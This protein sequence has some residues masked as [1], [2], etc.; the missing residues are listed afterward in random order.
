M[1]QQQQHCPFSLFFFVFINIQTS[2][3][4][5]KKVVNFSFSQAKVRWEFKVTQYRHISILSLKGL[6]S[7][8]P[9]FFRQKCKFHL[10]TSLPNALLHMVQFFNT[11]LSNTFWYFLV[12]SNTALSNTSQYFLILSNTALSNTF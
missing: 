4:S 7:S 9:D 6:F 12:L 8:F 2:T 11:A 10:R 1:Q 3:I 5:L